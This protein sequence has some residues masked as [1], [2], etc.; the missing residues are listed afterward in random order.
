MN[1]NP[2]SKD[3]CP[4]QT[5]FPFVP[6]T[7]LYRRLTMNT[8]TKTLSA[9]T[10]LALLTGSAHAEVILAMDGGGSST[11]ATSHSIVDDFSTDGDSIGSITGSFSS[12]DF[13]WA[14]ANTGGWDNSEP[15]F[16][17]GATTLSA[18]WIISGLTEGSQWQVYS[19]WREQ[20]NRSTA[21]P[22]T[23]NGVGTTVNQEL[24]PT[25][26]LALADPDGVGMNFQAVGGIVTVDGTGQIV[27][28][29]S[30][31]SD[32]WVIIDGVALRQ[33][34]PEPGSLAL[35]GL[36]GLLIARRRRK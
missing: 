14:G 4:G 24:V 6:F 20:S 15:A 12:D 34:V 5:D 35:L 21:A 17:P 27:V 16:G 32:D 30:G 13:T 18:T 11:T 8:T 10:G 26:D 9:L 2:M 19:T 25:A 28:T 33:V 31:A 22:Y 7:S 1:Q 23:I 36:G 29:Q 3:A